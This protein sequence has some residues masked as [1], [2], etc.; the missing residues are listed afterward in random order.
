MMGSSTTPDPVTEE[1]IAHGELPRK[2]RAEI[3][4]SMVREVLLPGFD[5][6]GIDTTA[7]RRWMQERFPDTS[8]A[9]TA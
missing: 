6:Q 4:T 2:Q 7:S 3:F 9:R 8:I 1:A 5:S